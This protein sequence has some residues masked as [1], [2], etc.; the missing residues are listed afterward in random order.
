MEVAAAERWAEELEA[1]KIPDEILRQ[2]PVPPW[3][4]PTRLFAST[5]GHN[6]ALHRHALEALGDGGSVLD[7]GCGGGAAS[8]PL[9]PPATE[10]IGVDDLPAMLEAFAQA[11]EAAGAHHT[12]VLGHWPEIGGEVPTADVV[13]CRNVVYNV[14]DIAPFVS[15]LTGHATRR[16]IVE[17]TD[18]HPSL[19]LAPLWTRFWNLA[20]P[21]GPTADLF[22]RVLHEIGIDPTVERETRPSIKAQVDPQEHLAFL[23]RRLCLDASRDDEIAAALDSDAHLDETTAVILAWPPQD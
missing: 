17:L 23:R 18:A 12:E 2:A 19:S 14:A 11:A 8:V 20:R 4:F 7:I 6:G 9:V 3:G 1:W 15:A 22:I 13:V 5:P 10:L 21:D 16:V